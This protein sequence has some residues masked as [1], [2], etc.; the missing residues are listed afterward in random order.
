MSG[1]A[2][3]NINIIASTSAWNKGN[4]GWNYEN[5]DART[6]KEINFGFDVVSRGAAQRQLSLQLKKSQNSTRLL[7]VVPFQVTS[8]QYSS[9][10]RIKKDIVKVDTSD[11][12]DRMR[13]IEL[14]E[15]GYTDKWRRVRDI[16]DE[17]VRGVIAQELRQVFPEHVKVLDEFAINDHGIKFKNFHQVS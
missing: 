1:E 17:R 5:N 3:G 6:S 13:R 2:G 8:V 16:E 9:D 15:Y 12:L 14:R 11:L 10:E 4:R 7:S